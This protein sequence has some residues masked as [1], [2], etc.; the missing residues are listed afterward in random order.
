METKRQ[1]A[2]L[3]MPRR[4]WRLLTRRTGNV[5]GHRRPE[6]Y[7]HAHHLEHARVHFRLG[8]AHAALAAQRGAVYGAV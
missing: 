2:E 5:E 1:G 4:L 6:V 3:G 7:S 8:A